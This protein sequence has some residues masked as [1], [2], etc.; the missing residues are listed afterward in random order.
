MITYKQLAK[1]PAVFSRLAGLTIT[2]FDELH[3]VFASF[4]NQFVFETFVQG[5]DRKRRYGGGNRP[6][7]ETSQDKLIF[8]LMYLRLYPIQILQ[9]LWFGIDESG[10]NR[11]IHRLTP[12][13]E[14]SL[15]F[16]MV[17]PQR[18]A[19]GRPRGRTL[20]E[21]LAEFPDLKDVLLDGM[22]Q[23]IRRPKKKEQQ[24]AAYSGKKKRHTKK[25]I[26]VTDSKRGY[27]HYLGK[28]QEGKKHD[29]AAA[30]EEE[31][32]GRSDIDIGTDLGFVG[33]TAGNAR[34]I[35]PMKK[36]KGK[37][38]SESIKKQNKLL[39]SIRIKVEHAICG[40][41][42]SRIAADTF[43]NVKEGF[44]DTSMLVA[45]GLHN[46]RVNHRYTG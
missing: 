4:W 10:A 18:K 25:N 16:R 19:G 24:K 11:W 17:L 42:R 5:K 2:E 3:D 37:E 41:K 32:S 7:I 12:L 13:M 45:V 38:L 1:R 44:A 23:P 40:V 28:T 31:L 27:V 46:L 8:I 6:V 33:Y 21:I 29:K 14:K 36:P 30:D 34:I 35:H 20:E 26:V 39:S 22:E 43:R 9:G 15:S